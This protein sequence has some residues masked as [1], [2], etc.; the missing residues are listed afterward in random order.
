MSEWVA[1][2]KKAITYY[3]VALFLNYIIFWFSFSNIT[4]ETEFAKS[5]AELAWMGFY[6]AVIVT[7]IVVII[8]AFIS[9]RKYRNEVEYW[10]NHSLGGRR[11]E[12]SSKDL[13][14]RKFYCF[15]MGGTLVE[16]GS[17]DKDLVILGVTPSELRK[18]L[19]ETDT[20]SLTVMGTSHTDYAKIVSSK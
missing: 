2:L 12:I 10:K 18:I 11:K 15:D 4:L 1:F 5:F 9:F 20:I 14:T 13:L 8:L 16:N 6:I 3:A 19:R 7:F 17:G